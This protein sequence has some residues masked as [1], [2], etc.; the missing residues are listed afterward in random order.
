MRLWRS[1]LA[2]LLV[3]STGLAADIVPVTGEPI[4]GE[5]VSV[6]DKEVVFT[7]G[8]K[9]VT[10]PIKEILKL[11]YRDV[12]KL[13]AGKSFALVELTD[14]TQLFAEKLLLKK[15]DF[16]LTLLSGPTMTLPWEAVAN[17]LFDAASEENRREWKSRVFNSRGKDV[18]VTKRKVKD[19]DREYEIA[20]N[21]EATFGDGDETGTAIR[22]AVTLGGQTTE[23]TRKFSTL[24]GLIFKHTLGAKAAPFTCK[25]LDT[26][27]NVVMVSSVAPRD[28]GLVV[29]TPSGAKIDFGNEQIARLDYTQGR[30]EYLSDLTPTKMVTRSN[31]DE[32]GDPDQWHVFKDSNLDKRPMT[33]AGITYPKG[34]ALK[35][36]AE[37]V[38]DLKGEY[39]EFEAVVGI[40]DGVS[41]AGA[42]TL[43]VEIDGKELATV[44]IS[45]DDKVRHR[46]LKLNVKDARA[47]RV[48][49]KADGEF[50]TARH[51]NLA[52][53]KVR[54]EDR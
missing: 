8:G 34:L 5:V 52:D 39:R 53:A 47:L 49:V 36:Y 20:S 7:Q 19:R 25:L 29:T 2:A 27:Q 44:T 18:V 32:D 12:G 48:V 24:R 40:D 35:P 38:F 17:V 1:L 46:P 33:I 23:A 50:D 11:D 37:L 43:L 54:K 31:L 42:S 6:T 3:V 10:R 30:L 21:L 41:A 13:P 16:D 28:G 14:G 26:T 51:L 45:S 22:F 4:K 15:R 9:K